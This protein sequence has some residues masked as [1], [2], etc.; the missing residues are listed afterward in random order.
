FFGALPPSIPFIRDGK[1]RALAVTSATRADALP[2]TP[3]V[4]DFLPDFEANDWT[5]LGIPTGT[6]AR[7]VDKLNQEVRAALDDPRIKARGAEVGGVGLGGSPADF[8]RLIAED[9]EK[10]AKVVRFSGARVD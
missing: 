1:L 5:G 6:P 3:V 2:D 7:I 9:T 8:G 4:G 10:W